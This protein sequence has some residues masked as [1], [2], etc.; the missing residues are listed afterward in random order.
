M[1]K[2][3]LSIALFLAFIAPKA[4]TALPGPFLSGVSVGQSESA[5]FN[6]LKG[7]FSNTYI[8][9]NKTQQYQ[10][11]LRI[12]FLEM[13]NKAKAKHNVLESEAFIVGC[14]NEAG[15]VIAAVHNKRVTTIFETLF[16]PLTG[17]AFSKTKLSKYNNLLSTYRSSCSLS[18][19]TVAGNSFIYTG[20]C[21]SSKV[22][23]EYLPQDN[24]V[25]VVHY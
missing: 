6:A 25:Y 19:H 16:V 17:D 10:R 5:A 1:L 11:V 20:S 23:W 7:V 2:K 18:P 3:I 12:H 4:A 14:D 21:G 22:R 13:L 9:S 24:I 15:C 8:S